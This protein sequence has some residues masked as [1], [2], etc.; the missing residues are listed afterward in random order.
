MT[1]TKE[2]WFGVCA[3]FVAQ[4]CG[5]TGRKED[6]RT[7]R[8][9]LNSAFLRCAC[10]GWIHPSHTFLF[11]EQGVLRMLSFFHSLQVRNGR[12]WLRPPFRREP[13]LGSVWAGGP[14]LLHLCDW[15]SQ[16]TQWWRAK[17]E[18]WGCGVFVQCRLLS[19]LV[20]ALLYSAGLKVNF[21]DYAV[22]PLFLFF[23]KYSSNNV[24]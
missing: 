10:E 9:P 13:A 17:W 21:Q 18:P 15:L 20:L 8:S 7:M 1:V 4:K 19:R 6:W 5:V 2:S 12:A 11:G 23:S 3:E 24:Y 14:Q 22:V 16:L